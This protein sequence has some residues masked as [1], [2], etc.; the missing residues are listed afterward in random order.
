MKYKVYRITNLINKKKY[1]GITVQ[2]L[3]NRFNA[4]ISNANKG[5]ERYLCRA[6][7]KY[8]SSNFKIELIDNTSKNY[9]EL[10]EK[11]TYYISKFNTFAPNG[12]NMTKGGEGSL[13]RITKDET[14]EKMRNARL[15]KSSWNKGIK[16]PYDNYWKGKHLPDEV[17]LKISESHKGKTVSDAT[18]KKI[19]ESLK[20]ENSPCYGKPKTLEHRMKI[21]QSKKG[22]GAVKYKATNNDTVIIFN[23]LKDTLDF[24]NMKGH[25]S[26]MNAVRNKTIY[27]GYYWEKLN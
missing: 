17:K 19:S 8:G 13:G 5:D 12:Y 25:V 27:K 10:L 11:E 22:Q 9:K 24:L 7:R 20:G 1:I 2:T 26:L 23:S 6:I 3:K 16:L 15:G 14:R 18:R 4:H 21:S